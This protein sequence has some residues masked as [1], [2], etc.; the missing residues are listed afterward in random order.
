M[1][2]IS[3]RFEQLII[4]TQKRLVASDNM[5]PIIESGGIKVGSVIITSNGPLKMLH[6]GNREV[7]TNINLNLV[8]IRLAN[9]L[10]KASNCK[11]QDSIYQADQIY[12][13]WLTNC[14]YLQNSI[15]NARRTMDFEKL[16]ILVAKYIDSKQK[17]DN[18]KQTALRL[19][20]S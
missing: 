19:A 3:A 12:G 1:S 15:D 17:A 11:L 8:T 16:D 4:S 18:A 2:D 9:L 20:R 6:K 7:F 14:Q 13:K 10:A 5:L